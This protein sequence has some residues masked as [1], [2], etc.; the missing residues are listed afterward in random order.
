LGS[1]GLALT[2]LVAL[3]AVPGTG[4]LHQP[5]LHTEVDDLAVAIDAL[6]VEDLELGLTERR[7]HLVLD[8]LHAGLTAHHL[9][10]ILHRAGAADIQTYRGIELQSVTT[11][12]GFRATEHHANL[13]ADLVDEDH[14][15]VVILDVTG[16]LA[17]GL[18]HQAG[19]QA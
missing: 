9:F 1:I 2:N 10:A 6:A 7:S 3:I 8:D 14:Q 18:R 11:G 16:D 4:F 12:G 5:L 19:L 13:H 17:Q 15:A